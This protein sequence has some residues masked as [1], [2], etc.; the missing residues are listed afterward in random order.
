MHLKCSLNLWPL[1]PHRTK[2]VSCALIIV[3]SSLL[4]S[5]ALPETDIVRYWV[6]T[7]HSPKAFS[8]LIVRI[9]KTLSEVGAII[10]FQVEKLR[11][12]EV[13]HSPKVTEPVSD[14]PGIVP[15]GPPRVCGFE[16]H[17]PRPHLPSGSVPQVTAAMTITNT[18]VPANANLFSHHNSPLNSEHVLV[19]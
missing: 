5:C 17:Q 4:A 18:G 13:K 15:R 10:P 8:C 19:Q 16:P 12:G 9:F 3:A 2:L 11:P 6:Y 1:R 14:D 7:R